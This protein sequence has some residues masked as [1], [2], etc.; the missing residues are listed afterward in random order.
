MTLIGRRARRTASPGAVYH[1]TDRLHCR[2]ADRVS[3]DRI[4]A[5]VAAWLAELGADSPMVEEL[6]HAVR[7]GDW[8]VA[9]SLED[10]L[11]VQISIAA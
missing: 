5:V 1:I 9:H 7:A 11:S 8:P 10:L 6:A 2:R 3:S 4:A